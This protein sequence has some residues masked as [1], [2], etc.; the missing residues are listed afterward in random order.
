M[1]LIAPLSDRDAIVLFKEY[2]A[3]SQK[4]VTNFEKY[5][6][7]ESRLIEVVNGFD[8]ALTMKV[9][10]DFTAKFKNGKE[11]RLVIEMQYGQYTVDFGGNVWRANMRLPNHAVIAKFMLRATDVIEF[12]IKTQDRNNW[13]ML[14]DAEL[15]AVD[16]FTDNMADFIIQF[17]QSKNPQAALILETQVSQYLQVANLSICNSILSVQEKFGLTIKE[18]VAEPPRKVTELR[19]AR[20]TSSIA[21]EQ[22][23]QMAEFTRLASE[24]KAAAKERIDKLKA[25]RDGAFDQ[26]QSLEQ[27]VRDMYQTHQAELLEARAEIDR[28]R[29]ENTNIRVERLCQGVSIPVLVPTPPP[30]AS[31]PV[32]PAMQNPFSGFD[33]E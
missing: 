28:L 29:L 16:N 10:I 21:L 32:L 19:P 33:F 24:F 12:V 25:E 31:K 13:R 2:L 4:N 17:H 6:E 8:D 20:S 18:A 3:F 11:L 5:T 23:S 26:V 30:S 22:T 9:N 7:I 15:V 14:S 1:A 27:Q